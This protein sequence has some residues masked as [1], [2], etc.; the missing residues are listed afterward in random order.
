MTPAE[1]TPLHEL[2]AHVWDAIVVGAGPAG[3]LAAHGLA[4]AGARVLLVD[5]ATF[6]RPKVCGCCLSSRAIAV[7]DRS[8]LLPPVAALR[9]HVYDRLHV[10]AGRSQT[11][12]DLPA[13]LSVSRER[14]DVALI[15]RAVA[16]GARFAPA[17]LATTE[18]RSN[19]TPL[20]AL[21]LERPSDG[22]TASVTCRVV[23]AATGLGTGFAQHELEGESISA[24]SR[25]G[26]G[27][28]MAAGAAAWMDGAINMAI[29]TE[30]YVGAVRLEDGRWNLAAALDIEAVK[31]RRGIAPV[32][33]AIL[34]SVGWPID[35]PADAVGWRGTPRLSRRPRRVAAARLFAIGDAAGYVEPFTG[36]GMACAL[37]A[38]RAVV[39]LVLQAVETWEP[40]LA[41]A[42][43]GIL[44][45][46]I[47]R[48]MAL[49]AIAAWSVRRPRLAAGITSLL[50]AWPDLATPAIKRANAAAVERMG[51]GL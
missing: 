49:P 16:A 15:E 11:T 38:G 26:A 30:G 46:D 22:C 25:V 32:V 21:R 20:P 4:A 33:T 6:P 29:G 7:L 19:S 18:G 34:E 47:Q 43:T 12:L 23:V 9:P 31:R 17:V 44:R 48:R 36:E 51:G 41:E 24:T 3:A 50:A 14:L 8:G 2:S 37:E 1:H 40:G 27:A 28:A 10:A 42:W 35:P 45:K 13:G 39:A 5:R